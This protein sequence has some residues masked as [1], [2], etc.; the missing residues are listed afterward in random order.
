MKT[1]IYRYLTPQ[2]LLAGAMLLLLILISLRGDSVF[3]QAFTQGYSADVP[4]QRGMIVEILEEDTTKVAPVTQN[5]PQGA[6]GVVVHKNDAPATIAS[7]GQEVFVANE[8]KYDILVSSQNG[9]IRPG[10][11]IV[12]S[13]L[14]GIGMKVDEVQPIVVARA[15]DPFEGT[16]GD[17]VSQATVGEKTVEIGRI[18]ADINVAGNPLQRPP[19]QSLPDILR[20]AAEAVAQKPVS[21]PRLYLSLAL[22]LVS[23]VVSGVLLYGG[24]RSGIISIGRN[25]LSK[26]SIIRG[27]IQVIIV[28]LLIFITGIFGV[29]LLL[30]L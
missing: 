28:G 26:K 25:P 30:K 19:D 23:A 10:D 9:P 20:R 11:Y 5:D 3:A 13:S 15:L 16:G 2:R 22:L 1:K 18:L 7:E 12:M 8:G 14:N 17:S 21:T 24:I 6:Y 27:M 29:Y 4:L